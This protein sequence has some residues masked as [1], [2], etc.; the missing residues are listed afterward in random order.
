M[1]EGQ[2]RIVDH[3]NCQMEFDLAQQRAG[4]RRRGT[5]GRSEATETNA[6]LRKRVQGQKRAHRRRAR[7][8]TFTGPRNHLD[9]WDREGGRGGAVTLEE[10]KAGLA[11]F[12]GL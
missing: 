1:A 9:Q 3:A 11:S 4:A 6:E 2:V 10:T 8:R 5:L 7:P 12:Q